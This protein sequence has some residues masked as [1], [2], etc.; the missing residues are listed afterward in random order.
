MV[1]RQ[2]RLTIPFN[3]ELSTAQLWMM[4]REAEEIIDREISSDEKRKI[5]QGLTIGVP[6]EGWLTLAGGSPAMAK[7]GSH[8]AWMAG[9]DENVTF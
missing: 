7:A 1:Y 9:G 6:S 8:L 5:C 3:N 2:Y 4:I